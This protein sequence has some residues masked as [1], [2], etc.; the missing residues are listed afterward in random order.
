MKV[1]HFSI[2]STIT[3][4]NENN[5]D[6]KNLQFKV[7]QWHK[8]NK[9]RI[10]VHRRNTTLQTVPDQKKFPIMN[11]NKEKDSDSEN[12]EATNSSSED[13]ANQENNEI[14]NE[15]KEQSTEE[16]DFPRFSVVNQRDFNMIPFRNTGQHIIQMQRKPSPQSQMQRAQLGHPMIQ[17]Q[18][19]PQGPQSILAQQQQQQQIFSEDTNYTFQF[20][21]FFIQSSHNQATQQQQRQESDNRFLRNA[22]IA[23]TLLYSQKP[24]LY[25]NDLI[26]KN[27]NYPSYV[28]Q[29]HMASMNRATPQPQPNPQ[30]QV[31]QT[32]F[33]SFVSKNKWGLLPCAEKCSTVPL[34]LDKSDH[35]FKF[36]DVNE[37]KNGQKNTLKV[38]DDMNFENKGYYSNL[39]V[40]KDGRLDLNLRHSDPALNLSLIEPNLV[41][42]ENFH[43]PKFNTKL[44]LGRK[45]NVTFKMEFD[46]GENGEAALSPFLKDLKSLSGR[47]GQIIIVEHTSEAPP[48]I[49]NVGMA[50]RLIVYWHKASPTDWPKL[51]GFGE[52]NLHIL[53]PDQ[54][55]P[56]IAQIPRNQPVPS[57]N[58]LLY[59]VPIAEHKI[60]PVDFLLIKSISKARFYIRKFNAIYCAGYI[61]PKQVVMRPST[62]TAQDFH[63]DF[64]KA[65]LINIF[66]GTEQH[67]GRRRIQVSQIQ[68]EFFPGVNEP[69]LRSVL[70][71][72]ANFYR[73]QSNGFWER[74]DSIDLDQKFQM[75]EITPEMVCRY[76]S[77]LVGLWKLRKNGVHIL[78]RS[79]RV[80]QQIQNLH[81]EL[82]RKVAEKIEL[83][84]M[85]TPWSRTDN[86][87]KAFQGH[88]VQIEHTDDGQQVVRSKSRRGKSEP[89]DGK[90]HVSSNRRQLAGTPSDLRSLTCR[91][92]REK[93]ISL[94]VLSGTI[95][96][97]TRWQQVA[98]LRQCANRQKQDGSISDITQN[99]SRGP[100]NDYAASL[101]AY[102][103]QYQATFDNNLSFINTIN[104]VGKD[105]FDD[106]N[107][108]DDIALQ[109]TRDDDDD[110]ETINLQEE[111]EYQHF[112]SKGDPPQL[113]PY[114][115]YTHPTKI[116]WEK[117]GFVNCP[118]RTIAKL[119]TLSWSRED[120]LQVD[121]HWRRSPHQIE[122][123]LKIPSNV[124][125]D[126]GQKAPSTSEDLEEHILKIQ[127]KSLLD[128]V[129][130]TKQASRGRGPKTPVQSYLTVKHQLPIVN[131]TGNNLT[132]HLTPEITKTILEAS[133]RFYLFE[134]RCGKTHSKKKK[135]SN[136]KNSDN[137]SDDSTEVTVAPK[138][139][140]GRQ[141]PLVLFNELIKKLLGRLMHRPMDEFWVFVKPVLKKDV[142][143]YYNVVHNPMCFEDIERKA[144]NLEYTTITKF[145]SDVKLIETNCILYNTGRNQDIVLLG[146]KMMKEFQNEL[147]TVRDELDQLESEI[148]PVLRNQKTI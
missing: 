67:P 9:R 128:K 94:G 84:L 90:D 138:R 86:F 21:S 93:L 136:D 114:G 57:I 17:R 1:Q 16:N 77:M 39:Y 62:K 20:E 51:N 95:D 59:S 83:E 12:E 137:E 49:M 121:I 122:S 37:Q 58:C 63:M 60:E 115:I 127:R 38:W 107:I 139:R 99:Y 10:Y 113:V 74:N 18:L 135:S 22:P 26:M 54:V 92:L 31:I 35:R 19:S 29:S 89:N 44:V 47:R 118:M 15:D 120:G 123:L 98:L 52:D 13:N 105:D 48:F 75:I 97:L 28:Q 6:I 108:L 2:Y 81:G 79:K 131:D 147:S 33:N 23:N 42:F 56:F 91:E 125:Q 14:Q 144:N 45:L 88:A 68:N 66:R 30:P 73:E 103:K 101:D 24:Y 87:S 119:I 70:R 32:Y 140:I 11:N 130:R 82:T 106:G 41:D 111:E 53:E 117:Y 50:S 126:P 3:A 141:S 116:D 64:I 4:E 65:I 55:A 143:D 43:H 7:D 145:Y 80:Y 134:S 129:R 102:K 104:P 110:D 146:D 27:Y 8:Q 5:N 148:D 71:E 109:M 133:E 76:Q 100:R 34:I 69:K 46:I 112:A 36:T 85:K 25:H 40:A 142:P 124:Y 96:Q 61:E 78:T 132:F 72:F